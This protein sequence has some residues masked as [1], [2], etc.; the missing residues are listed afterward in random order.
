[1]WII[2]RYSALVSFLCLTAL[3]AGCSSEV[4]T[5]KKT[6]FDEEHYVPSHWPESVSELSTNFDRRLEPILDPSQQL[7]SDL[8][9]KTKR[10]LVDLI[11]W[12]PEITANSSLSEAQWIPIYELAERLSRRLKQS[13]HSWSSDLLE[14]ARELKGLLQAAALHCAQHEQRSSDPE[15][16]IT[17][18][19]RGIR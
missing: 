12:T 2:S 8:F 10:E 6:L 13:N 3:L 16:S 14:M 11:A 5:E 15:L 7:D 17:L 18:D 19:E 9:S 4:A 1:M